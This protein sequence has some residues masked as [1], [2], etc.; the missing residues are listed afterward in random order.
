MMYY[1]VIN[2]ITYRGSVIAK[3]IVCDNYSKTE[4][5]YGGRHIIVMYESVLYMQ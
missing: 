5:I 3:R 1:F 2:F 4:A